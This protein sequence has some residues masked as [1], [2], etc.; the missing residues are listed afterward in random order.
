[1]AERDHEVVAGEV[2]A[3]DGGG[4]ERQIM[5]VAAGHERQPLDERGH[6][7]PGLDH[8][9][10]AARHVEQRVE[11]RLREQLAEHLQAAL[12]AAHAGEPV[13]DERHARRPGA[14]GG[15]P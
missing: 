10:H 7:A 4:K 5:T 6:D 14:A 3:A 15:L 1:V 2:E 12:A 11:R 13:V 8:G 9:R